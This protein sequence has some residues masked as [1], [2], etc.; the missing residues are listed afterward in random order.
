GKKVFFEKII[1]GQVV[2]AGTLNSNPLC[3]AA[4]KWCLDAALKED[5]EHQHPKRIQALGKRLTDG[6][7]K[8]A[9]EFGIPLRPQGPGL[10]FFTM[11]LKD[12]AAEGAATNYR[13]LVQRH[14]AE[15]WKHLRKCLLERGVRA[16]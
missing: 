15:R 16:I 12:G 1:N 14:D 7:R 5:S 2:H 13:D 6:L 4:S 3:L 8:L 10:V 11:M 9:D